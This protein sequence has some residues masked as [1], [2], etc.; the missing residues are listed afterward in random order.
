MS[1]RPQLRRSVAGGI[2]LWVDPEARRKGL[3][4]AFSDRRG[5]T[6]EAPFDS[7]NLAARVGDNTDHVMENRRL[8]GHAAGF[9]PEKIA[10]IRQV[11]GSE[12]VEVPGGAAGRVGEGDV[13]VARKPGSVLGILTADCVP[14]I[15]LGDR[16][17]A[18]VHAGWRGLVAG[19]I[20]AGVAAVQPVLAAWIGPGIRSCCYEVGEEVVEAFHSRGLPVANDDHV[21]PAEAAR[22]VLARSGVGNIA[23]NGHCTGHNPNYFSYRREGVTGRQGAFVS[24]AK[25]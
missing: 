21:D 18:V 22:F 2:P 25:R 8:V 3:I 23:A 10:L 11:H 20:E 4:V 24:I 12:V 14:L 13:L 5:G 19:A 1:W 9:D 15:L 6:S 17:V 7:L 16:G